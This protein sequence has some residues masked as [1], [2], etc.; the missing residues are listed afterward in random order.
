MKIGIIVFSFT[1]NTYSVAEK[2]KSKLIDK[3]CSVNIERVEIEGNKYP[4]NDIFEFKN[5]PETGKYDFIIFGS[6]VEAF[7]LSRIMKKYLGQISSLKNKKVALFVTEFFPYPWMGGNNAIKV[8]KKLCEDKDATITETG[9]V[10]W[11]NKKRNKMIEN[12]VNKF[13]NLF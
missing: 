6:P 8:M 2:I 5:I 11:K 7:S 10:N 13:S 9:V 3:G 4:N 12:I 1:G